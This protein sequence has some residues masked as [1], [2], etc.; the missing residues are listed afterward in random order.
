MNRPKP[1]NK[2]VLMEKQPTV[3][4][5]IKDV[6]PY[7][8]DEMQ[9]MAQ[10]LKM[11]KE[12]LV[13]CAHKPEAKIT[14]EVKHTDGSCARVEAYDHAAFVQGLYDAIEYFMSEL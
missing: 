9:L 1:V 3:E 12:A 8:N 6:W 4:E 5:H 2:Q 7:L 11:V 13:Y 14:I 10:Q